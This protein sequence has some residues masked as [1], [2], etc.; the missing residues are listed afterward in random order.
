MNNRSYRI[1]NE[2][3]LEIKRLY[4]EGYGCKLI[5]QKIGRSEGHINKLLRGTFKSHAAI[6][7][8]LSNGKRPASMLKRT[9]KKRKK[10]GS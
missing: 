4:E 7:G 1:T 5:A 8:R 3:L 9:W 6:V 2:E 10:D